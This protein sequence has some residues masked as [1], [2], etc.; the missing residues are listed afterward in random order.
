MFKL[1][2]TGKT[3]DKSVSTA[4][5]IWTWAASASLSGK[6]AETEL[7]LLNDEPWIGGKEIEKVEF[8]EKCE[9]FRAQLVIWLNYYSPPRY[10]RM[11]NYW[12]DFLERV[13]NTYNNRFKVLEHTVDLTPPDVYNAATSLF[14]NI[15]ANTIY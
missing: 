13:G 4:F 5:E 1:T 12:N 11:Q 8:D 2:G 7:K 15:H 10:T 9:E 14:K 3:N 6:L